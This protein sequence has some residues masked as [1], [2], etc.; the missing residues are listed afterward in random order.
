MQQPTSSIS[1]ILRAA[2]RRLASSSPTPRLD[3]ELLLAHLL[4]WPRARLLAE[5]DALVSPDN[6]ARLEALLTRRENLEPVA[7]LIGSKEFFGLEFAVDRRVLVPRPET[8]LLVERALALIPQLGAHACIADIGTGSGAIPVALA[9]HL[10]E[11]EIIA[12]DISPD[13]LAVA[14]TNIARHGVGGR[15]RLLLGDLLDVLPRGQSLDLLVSNPPYATPTSV[16]ENVRRHEPQLAL[17]AEEGGLAVYRRLLA[18]APAYLRPGAA[19]LLE[20]GAGQEET[21][22]ALARNAFPDA[23]IRV[24]PDLAGIARVL[25]VRT[26]TRQA[27]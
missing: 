23:Q 5:A 6:I 7:Y 17:F 18:S 22:A 11:A 25:E 24:Y 14:A 4:G 3:A 27:R 2:A 13:A 26:A 20:L 16:D 19:L 12:S 9:V 8:E 15:V 21:V 10:P 1:Q